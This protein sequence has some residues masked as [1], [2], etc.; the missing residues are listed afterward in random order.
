MTLLTLLQNRTGGP[1]PTQPVYPGDGQ[2]GPEVRREFKLRNEVKRKRLPKS[3]V[4]KVKKLAKTAEP[5]L[6][7]VREIAQEVLPQAFEIDYRVIYLNILSA[8]GPALARMEA[9]NAILALAEQERQRAIVR[10]KLMIEQI[11]RY[12]AELEEDELLLTYLM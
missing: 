5:T 12:L 10:E 9:E 8:L 7:Q 11:G 1:G 2:Q 6:E 3:V 4:K